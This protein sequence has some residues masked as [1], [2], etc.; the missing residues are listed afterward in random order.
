MRSLMPDKTNS[1]K[2]LQKKNLVS[3]QTKLSEYPQKKE[4]LV[5]GN[6]KLGRYKKEK[7]RSCVRLCWV[8]IYKNENALCQTMLDKYQAIIIKKKKRPKKQK[9]KRGYR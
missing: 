7:K 6:P 4:G 1:S 8:N 3:D 2:Y 9:G 5:P